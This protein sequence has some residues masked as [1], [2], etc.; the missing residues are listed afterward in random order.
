MDIQRIDPDHPLF[1]AW[2]DV[3]VEAGESDWGRHHTA[4]SGPEL[5][6]FWRKNAAHRHGFAALDA[7]AL[8]AGA[9]G[10]AVIGAVMATLPQRDN[11][12][13][14]FVDVAVRPEQRRR[15][16]G[17]SVLTSVEDFV[18]DQGRTTIFVETQTPAG[19]PDGA[20]PGPAFAVANGF[21]AAQRVVRGAQ[22]VPVR[23]AIASGM[24]AALA[25]DDAYEVHTC[26]GRL[27]REWESARARLGAMMSTD[28]PLGDLDL[29]PETIDEVRMVDEM[30]R[31]LSAGRTIVTAM[32]RHRPS[33]EFVAFSEV[34]VSAATPW[35][36][37]Q[38]DTLV[39]QAHRGHR[40]GYRVKAAVALLLPKA[41][42]CVE[43]QRTWNDETNAHMLRTNA[44]LGYVREGTMIEWQKVLT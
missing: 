10:G 4:Y 3:F 9:R 21:A 12:H 16:V 6:S 19:T 33:G 11:A 17:H 32:A 26:V 20:D 31:A 7:K 40:L 37:Y 28:T 23:P 43:V 36:A 5:H 24:R 38:D 39:E 15:G 14:A 29:Q 42:P 25:T 34:Q 2:A 35:I 27:P 13:L 22:P 30:E 8:A 18:R 1:P 44:E 41:A